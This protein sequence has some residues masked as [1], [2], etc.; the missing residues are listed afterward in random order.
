MRRSIFKPSFFATLALLFLF[1][2]AVQA[3][4]VPPPPPQQ[5]QGAKPTAEQQPAATEAAQ[6]ADAASQTREATPPRKDG[7][8]IPEIAALTGPVMVTATGNSHDGVEYISLT[9]FEPGSGYGEINTRPISMARLFF[10]ETPRAAGSIITFRIGG[11]FL[12]LPLTVQAV[13]GGFLVVSKEPDVKVVNLVTEHEYEIG[14]VIP[15]L[16][17]TPQTVVVDVEFPSP[18]SGLQMLIEKPDSKSWTAVNIARV[19]LPRQGP[20]TRP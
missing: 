15:Y 8:V 2:N 4:D 16:D 17:L 10:S 14:E 7:L 9:G 3:Q 12:R 13:F 20:P 11:A 18:V 5:T 1:F 19:R 6:T